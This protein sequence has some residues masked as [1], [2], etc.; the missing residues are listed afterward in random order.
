VPG[1]KLTAGQS[2]ADVF[3]TGD[4]RVTVEFFSVLQF[5]RRN[6]RLSTP[7]NLKA[8]CFHVRT[9][10]FSIGSKAFLCEP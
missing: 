10:P 6:Q 4:N 7:Q 5:A 2:Q 1:Q 8:V 3:W 9:R